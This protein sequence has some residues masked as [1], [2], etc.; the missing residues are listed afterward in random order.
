[1]I[2]MNQ[3]IDDEKFKINEKNPDKS[4]N[5]NYKGEMSLEKMNVKSKEISLDYYIKDEIF[6]QYQELKGYVV[7]NQ[8]TSSEKQNIQNTIEKKKLF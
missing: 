5:S 1:M 4:K 3:V 8:H 2:Q 7:T 6:S